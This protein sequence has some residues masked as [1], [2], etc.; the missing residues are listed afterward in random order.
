METFLN[1]FNKGL[2]SDFS[3][4][5]QPDGTYRYMRNCQLISQD[6][7]NYSIKDCLGNTRIFTINAPYNATYPNVGALPMVICFIS[8]PN[9]LI[10]LQTNNQSTGGYLEI[11][12]LNF[13]PYGEGIRYYYNYCGFKK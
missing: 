9:K 11:G 1:V 13:L 6:G 10:V 7:N 12:E 8:F 5:L 4:I 2:N 3:L